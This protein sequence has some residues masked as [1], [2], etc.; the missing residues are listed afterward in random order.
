[1]A[2]QELKCA[3]QPGIPAALRPPWR[4]RVLCL[5]LTRPQAC[6]SAPWAGSLVCGGRRSTLVPRRPHCI[7]KMKPQRRPPL[8]EGDKTTGER[9]CQGRCQEDKVLNLTQ[10]PKCCG[11]LVP[12]RGIFGFEVGAADLSP[13]VTPVLR[14]TGLPRRLPGARV[15]GRSPPSPEMLRQVVVLERARGGLNT[16]GPVLRGHRRPPPPLSASLQYKFSH[17]CPHSRLLLTQAFCHPC[18]PLA[19]VRIVPTFRAL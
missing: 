16:T 13:I 12:W 2:V 11:E 7:S 14:V 5:S 9:G 18:L 10:V 3:A 4:A 1:M 15:S 19:L 6:G 17:Q 8:V